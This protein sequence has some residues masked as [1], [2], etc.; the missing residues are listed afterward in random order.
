MS[1]IT[2]KKNDTK[3][4]DKLGDRMK[5]YEQRS[6]LHMLP[7]LP[8]IARVD[9]RSFSKFT[10]GLAQPYDTRMQAAMLRTATDLAMATQACASYTQSDEISLV[11]YQPS[12]RSSIWF[13]GKHS[14][15]V[16]Q[17]AA[18]AT[19]YFYR[20]VCELMPEYA[21]RLPSFDSRVFQ[22]PNEHEAVM[23]FIWRERDAIKNSITSAARLF[24]S[25]TELYK[26]N[27]NERQEMLFQKGINWDTY[28]DQFK[29]G[30]FVQRYKSMRSFTAEELERL[31]EHHAA[32]SNPSLQIE[33]SGYRVMYG[34]SDLSK[35]SNA[36]AFLLRGEAPLLRVETESTIT[37]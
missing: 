18:L 15:M 6:S 24:F 31:P 19:L 4:G 34:M 21:S 30:I 5:Q 14:K 36:A 20:A 23:A 11:W 13:E 29:R 33:R 12:M 22:V 37:K 7:T 8:I 3:P 32:R 35:L 27:S 16:S 10:A 2:H 17:T 26:K 25:P 9:G 1:L 28:P